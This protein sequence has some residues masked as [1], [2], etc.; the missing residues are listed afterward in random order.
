M[1]KTGLLI[2]FFHLSLGLFVQKREAV[3]YFQFSDIALELNVINIWIF[4]NVTFGAS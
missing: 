2:F 4:L 3:E 1:C